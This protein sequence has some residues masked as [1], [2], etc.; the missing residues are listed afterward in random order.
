LDTGGVAAVVQSY[1]PLSYALAGAG[2]L[3][4]AADAQKLLVG[5]VDVS[6]VAFAGKGDWQAD[7]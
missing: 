2:I 5:E 3:L 1:Q 4:E 6:Q 7:C